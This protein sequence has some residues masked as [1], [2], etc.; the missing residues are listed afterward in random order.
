MLFKVCVL[1]EDGSMT[2]TV[3][4]LQFFNTLKK[5]SQSR[6]LADQPWKGSSSLPLIKGKRKALLIDSLSW[7]SSLQ[8]GL[9]GEIKVL[10]WMV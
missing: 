8:F 7:K 6:I 2:L 1:M 5:D 3:S 4:R 9:A 10:A